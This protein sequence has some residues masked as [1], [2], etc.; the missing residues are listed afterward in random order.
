VAKG[1]GR[2]EPTDKV[3]EKP[4]APRPT[5]FDKL[6]RFIVTFQGRF[7]LAFICGED[8]RQRQGVLASLSDLLRAK[9][10][11]LRQIDLTYR[12]VGDL[13]ST[14]KEECRQNIPAAIVVTGVEA[15][16]KGSLLASLNIQR[17]LI[18][19][20]IHCPLLFWVSNFA[21]TVIARE[22]PDFYDFR[23]TVFNFKRA[24]D[25]QPLMSRDT[26]PRD[27]TTQFDQAHRSESRATFLVDQLERYQRN[28]SRLESRDRMAY[29]E[30]LE[31]V[32][33]S[34]RDNRHRTEALMYLER[35]LKIYSEL[36]EKGREAAVLQAIAD[37]Y[38]F[39]NNLVKA[40][41]NLAKA[42]P[43]YRE[44]GDRLGEANALRTLGDVKRMQGAYAEAEA[45]YQQALTIHRE[46]G[47]RR[48]EA[49]ALQSLGNVKRLQDAY[50][51]GEAF[52]QQALP[53]YREIGSRL[54]EAN[55]LRSLGDV[56]M[57]QG[58][59]AEAET[60]YQQTLV[61]HREIGSRLGEANALQ[62]LGDVKR[63]Q[64]AYAEA[65]QLYSKAFEIYAS[66]DDKYNQ[67]QTL[68]SLVEVYRTLGE[69]EKAR[70]VADQAKALLASLPQMVQKG[71]H[72]MQEL[73]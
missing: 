66:I 57:A 69:Q 11:E 25:S 18:S 44:V 17:D 24:R 43:I 54:G 63:L 20:E 7:A 16:L 46:I 14:L 30:L 39:A 58:A 34:Y 52:Y 26:V 23:Y 32:A 72:V 10:I 9:G 33:R 49:N 3:N 29:G 71:D 53:L 31:E 8:R 60:L 6:L 61:I 40:A 12:E 51:E 62:R 68:L 15:S 45:L 2:K 38:H 35:A 37:I 21:L 1:P 5:E 67:G 42:L 64:G 70:S 73:S 19:R 59:D 50:A 4:E 27:Y 36:Q 22:A 41:E 65:E 56:K 13:Y 48:G 28:E 55:V 47:G